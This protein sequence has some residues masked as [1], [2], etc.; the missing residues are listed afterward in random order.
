MCK[1]LNYE[2]K[3]HKAL[4]RRILSGNVVLFV[5]SGFSIGAIGNMRDEETGE[6]IPIPNVGQLKS[7]LTKEVLDSVEEQLP[8]KEICEDC[9]EDNCERYSQV[10]KELFKVSKVED[11]HHMYAKI[12]WKSIYTTNVDNVIEYVYEGADKKIYNVFSEKPIYTERGALVLYKLHGD[13]ICAPEKITFSTSDYTVN[14][15][16][17]NDYRFENLTAALKTDNFLFIGTSLND[18]GDFDI[19]CEQAD[20]YSVSNNHGIAHPP[21]A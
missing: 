20:V 19:K 7:I 10:M 14:A 13:A 5:G 18:E 9:Q 17:R 12:D 2:D 8:L 11:F 6:K 3:D 4:L 15:A 21:D 16:K 1:P